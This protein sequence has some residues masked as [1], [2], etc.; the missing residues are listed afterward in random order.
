M[1]LESGLVLLPIPGKEDEVVELGA[2]ADERNIFDGLFQYDVD[3]AGHL[4]GVCYPPQVKPVGVQLVVRHEH[5]AVGKLAFETTIRL[6]K[7]LRRYT[8]ITADMDLGRRPPLRESGD[9]HGKGLLGECNVVVV[10]LRINHLEGQTD[11]LSGIDAII[12]T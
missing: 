2:P 8:G 5:Q 12:H 10:E 3:M 9:E 11:E 6:E 7:E 4:V 1:L